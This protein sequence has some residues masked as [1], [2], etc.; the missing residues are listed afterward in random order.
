MILSW[1]KED[2]E[3]QTIRSTALNVILISEVMFQLVVLVI[4][5]IIFYHLLCFLIFRDV[6]RRE[7]LEKRE[8]KNN[9]KF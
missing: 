8:K 9:K 3:S 6:D 1:L 2:R 5:I 4:I 7:I